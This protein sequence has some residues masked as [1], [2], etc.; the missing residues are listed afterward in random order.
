MSL[1]AA[2]RANAAMV[3][4]YIEYMDDGGAID[5]RAVYRLLLAEFSKADLIRALGCSRQTVYKQMAH[6]ETGLEF[7][8]ASDVKL[9]S[10]YQYVFPGEPVPRMMD[11]TA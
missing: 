6:L 11:R 8:T 2:G 5:L 1:T 9:V 4:E 7:E 3:D 10:F